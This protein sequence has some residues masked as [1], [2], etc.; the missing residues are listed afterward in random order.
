MRPFVRVSSIEITHFSSIKTITGLGDQIEREETCSAKQAIP[1]W[2]C[3]NKLSENT[4]K[5]LK[6]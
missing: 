6:T 2:V 1:K 3:H 4:K 5:P